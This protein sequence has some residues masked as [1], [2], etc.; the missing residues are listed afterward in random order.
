MTPDFNLS[1]ID[2]ETA[3]HEAHTWGLFQQNVG[4]PQLRNPSFVMCYA[5][6]FYGKRTTFQSYHHDGYL[7]MLEGA[8]NVL[9][10][11]DAVCGWNSKSFDVKRLNAEFVIAGMPP[12]SPFKQ[13]DLMLVVKK[14]FRFASNKLAFVSKALGLEGKVSHEGHGLWVKCLE[15]DEAAWKLFRRYCVR[16]VDLLPKLYDKLL[17]WI[18]DHPNLNLFDGSGC[19]NCGSP[20]LTKQGFSYTGVGKFQ[21]YKCGNCG[22]WTKESKRIDGTTKTQEKF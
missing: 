5:A 2:I 21:R 4:L 15:G 8:W 11:S 12:P 3:P 22:T 7:E 6:K 13:I 17:P 16:D 1:F 19:P 18:T 10:Q 20:N 14:H 9:D